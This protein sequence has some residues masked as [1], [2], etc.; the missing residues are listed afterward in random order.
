MNESLFSSRDLIGTTNGASIG[1]VDAGGETRILTYIIYESL[2]RRS[3]I[4]QRRP[5]RLICET[6]ASISSPNYLNNVQLQTFA[7]QR[8]SRA[9]ARA[10][11]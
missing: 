2:T 4:Q 9:R 11:Y 10:R 5:W 6:V 1:D 3:S 8:Y 7:E